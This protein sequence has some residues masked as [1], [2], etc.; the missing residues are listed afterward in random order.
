VATQRDDGQALGV[1]PRLG[2]ARLGDLEA[3]GFARAA[4]YRLLRRGLVER[5]GRGLDVTSD[6][7]FSE[8]HAL[9]LVAKQVPDGVVCLVSAVQFHE[10]GTQL[11]HEA[12]VAIGG[13]ARR[14]QLEYPPLRIV[15]FSGAALWEGVEDHRVEGVAGRMT[16]IAKT[17]AD[18]FKYRNKI[19]LEVALEARR[20]AWAERKVPMD[21]IDRFARAWSA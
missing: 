4:V 2:V 10:L 19:G 11:P 7:E 1:L 8:A 16:S 5:A 18:P 21:A 12:W 13:K 20:V 17:L 14:P 15:R 6:H 9:A 3:Q